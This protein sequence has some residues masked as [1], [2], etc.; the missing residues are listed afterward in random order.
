[1][2]NP[3]QVRFMKGVNFRRTADGKIQM[4]T[5]SGDQLFGDIPEQQQDTHGKPQAFIP[6]EFVATL[7]GVPALALRPMTK[8]FE[9]A[10]RPIE[11]KA[12]V[13]VSRFA[14]MRCEDGQMLWETPLSASRLFCLDMSAVSIWALMADGTSAT[15]ISKHTGYV[16][17]E[18]R[19]CLELFICAGLIDEVDHLGHLAEEND[20][21]L[22]MWAFHEALFHT[23]SRHGLHN[24]RIGGLYP[25][26]DVCP[27][28]P[29]RRP[30]Y[31]GDPIPLPKPDL[32][33]LRRNDPTLTE[34]I[35]TRCS[36]RDFDNERSITLKQIGHLLFRTARATGVTPASVGSYEVVWRPYPTGG[37]M[38]DIE[39]YIA[40]WNCNGLKYGFYHYDS[41]DHALIRLQTEKKVIEELLTGARYSAAMNQNPPVLFILSSR[42]LRGQWKYNGISYALSLKN[43]GALIQTVYLSA[44]AMGL[45]CCAL[46]VGD[47]SVFARATECAWLEETSVGEL[48]LGVPHSGI[49]RTIKE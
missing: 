21:P 36:I 16:L 6:V 47:I 27:P 34:L 10:Y 4:Q 23:R 12:R 28:P 33:V 37:G 26:K 41:F 13:K 9:L 2:E 29:G 49:P 19:H 35:E 45:G 3:F 1:M 30:P 25:F 18:I 14:L 39:I 11:S 8:T 15:T 43:V 38:G 32:D 42:Q 48:I 5:P 20:L 40:I 17:N 24:D 31:Q 44:Q 7:D 46:G 22:R